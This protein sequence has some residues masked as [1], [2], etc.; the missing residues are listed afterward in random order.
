MEVN[1][2][3]KLKFIAILL[4][5]ISFL[6]IIPASFA[7]DN[8]T[9][10]ALTGGDVDIL[11]NDYYFDANIDNDTGDGTKL[12]PYKELTLS[13][14]EDN[15]II[16]LA[17]GGYSLKWNGYANN[18]T[19]IGESR[20]STV[21]NA[22]GTTLSASSLT[23][24]NLTLIRAPIS[25]SGNLTAINSV[26]KDSAKSVITSSG[27]NCYINLINCTFNNNNY[28]SGTG[29]AINMK[30]GYLKI[31]DSV[32]SNNYA[33][34]SGGAIYADGVN[35]TVSNSKFINDTSLNDAGGA[36]FI[37]DS[38]QFACINVEFNNCMALLEEL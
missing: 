11:A 5:L 34:Y 19:I 32:F 37:I 31:T 36:I 25:A 27:N 38:P 22:R 28:L 30:G 26:F 14:I 12:N 15:S 21:I 24:C 1:I 4:V 20:E 35:A 17:N 29:S 23:L 16:H 7:E 10:I 18:V 3:S 6:F 33:H 2:L 13:R 9:D 8:Q